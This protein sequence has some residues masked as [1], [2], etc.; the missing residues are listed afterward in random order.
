MRDGVCTHDVNQVGR[1]ESID[2]MSIRY[3][4]L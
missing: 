4:M 2:G 3:N 1:T